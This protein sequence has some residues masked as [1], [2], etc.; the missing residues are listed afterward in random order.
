MNPKTMRLREMERLPMKKTKIGAAVLSLWMLFGCQKPAVSSGTSEVSS[1][2]ESSKASSSVE[3]LYGITAFHD[4][5]D[6]K[7]T[8]SGISVGDRYP[9]GTSLSAIFTFD[10]FFAEGT[11]AYVNEM[12]VP[13]LQNNDK[14]E[15]YSLTFV[16]PKEDVVLTLAVPVTPSEDGSVYTVILADSH[17]SVWGIESGKKYNCPS[18]KIF[19]ED[20]YQ[21][22]AS[23][24]L[25][26]RALPV[27]VDFSLENYDYTV[28]AHD[29]SNQL[30]TEPITV[31]VSTQKAEI[32]SITYVGTGNLK[33]GAVLPSSATPG[34][35]VEVKSE[36]K[37]NLFFAKAT[38]SCPYL[39]EQVSSSFRF[40]MPNEDLTVTF[41]FNDYGKVVIPATDYLSGYHLYS[42]SALT[43]EVQGYHPGQ[44]LYVK[45]TT[46]AEYK[47]YALAEDSG[48]NAV[49][50]VSDNVYKV[51]VASDYWDT[52]SLTP[53]VS[54]HHSVTFQ[55]VAHV[56]F[57][58]LD[59]ADASVYPGKTVKFTAV[60]EEGYFVTSVTEA[61]GKVYIS[62]GV[63][64]TTYEFTSIAED[65]EIT[66]SATDKVAT[67]VI[68]ALMSDSEPSYGFD[69][70]NTTSG[71]T[72]CDTLWRG[73]LSTIYCQTKDV[74]HCKLH[75]VPVSGETSVD[76]RLSNKVSV[77]LSEAD[78]CTVW[79]FT[80]TKDLV[81][82]IWIQIV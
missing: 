69:Y 74:I 9:A 36:I 39:S 66:A 70:T 32:K 62:G 35:V 81:M 29:A 6:A 58:L 46:E 61:D 63:W 44:D 25:T 82:E 80:V 53:S 23:A 8:L 72:W 1:L 34:D 77:T 41:N 64:D 17:A 18:F 45:F 67:G 37:E 73:S 22:H 65:V 14:P 79:D 5:T 27:H 3:T 55:T 16:M 12:A 47:V 56:T 60:P 2:P 10:A 50:F 28:D 68:V 33:D 42:D 75:Y 40:V 76:V 7:A 13:L 43:T 71:K 4:M 54:T 51:T 49:S 78:G 19:H 15:E 59:A 57:T 11:M 48:R 30:L 31:Y 26:D 38:F 20:G 52:L 21:A 24:Y